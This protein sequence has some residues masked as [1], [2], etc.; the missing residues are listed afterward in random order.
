[1]LF[2]DGILFETFIVY[3]E[4][5]KAFKFNRLHLKSSKF[6]TQLSAPP[7]RSAWQIQ[8]I[9]NGWQWSA[10]KNWIHHVKLFTLAL[11]W[12]SLGS[13]H[14]DRKFEQNHLVYHVRIKR[15]NWS[16]Q[17]VHHQRQVV[18]LEASQKKCILIEL[19][20]YFDEF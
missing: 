15:P 6:S 16:S 2:W 3:Y 9:E 12:Y 19:P 17:R 20:M 8:I 4:R 1:M 5:S 11:S 14:T 13:N 7:Y 10:N 18:H